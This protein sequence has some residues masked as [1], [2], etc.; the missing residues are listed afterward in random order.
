MEVANSPQLGRSAVKG[1]PRPEGVAL[2][3]GPLGPPASESVREADGSGWESFF[4]LTQLSRRPFAP[5]DSAP[6]SW[7]V[8]V[9]RREL[10]MQTLQAKPWNPGL[11]TPGF[12]AK[13]TF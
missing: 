8:P 13:R 3:P 5:H 2:L 10:S 11:G 1:R 12:A 6:S 7:P 4:I 9:M